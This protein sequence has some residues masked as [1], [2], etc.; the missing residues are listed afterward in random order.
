MPI[1]YYDEHNETTKR[2]RYPWFLRLEGICVLATILY[3]GR[4]NYA[5]IPQ[6]RKGYAPLESG[7]A[8]R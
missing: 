7:A 3:R 5:I 8:E 2:K 4:V 1:F 6:K